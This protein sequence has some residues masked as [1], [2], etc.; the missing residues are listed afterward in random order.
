MKNNFERLVNIALRKTNRQ[1]AQQAYYYA[2]KF[3]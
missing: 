3:N 1:L 2:M